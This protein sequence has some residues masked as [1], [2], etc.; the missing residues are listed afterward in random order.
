[1]TID[2]SK[3]IFYAPVNA[4]D[5]ASSGYGGDINTTATQTTAV[6]N[7][8]FTN[9]TN[10]QRLSGLV[11]YRKQFLRNEN[12]EAIEGM[13][14]WISSNTPSTDDTIDIC[15]AGTLSVLGATASVG[16]ATY[17]ES[18]TILTFQDLDTSAVRPGEWV[19]SVTF[20]ASMAS[21]REVTAVATNKITIASAFGSATTGDDVIAVCPAT[22]FTYSAPAT[23]GEAFEV[24]TIP[25]TTAMG[26]W[27]RR[28]V[29]AGSLGY[30]NNT[31][32]VKW[33]TE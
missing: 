1:M 16:V 14:V 5:P 19:Y 24:G 28:T 29:N 15:Q 30:T 31:V 13:L 33:E 26:V 22:M 32:T 8:E 6:K 23:K 27:K 25:A 20:D 12:D 9:V 11:D 21:A 3:L 2:N 4:T 7:N 18:A 10:S 17:Y